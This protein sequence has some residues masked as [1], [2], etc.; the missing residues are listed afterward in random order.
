MFLG[1]DTGGTFTDFV[2]FHEGIL[3]FH[4][5]LSTP[6]DPSRAIL[7][8]IH[9]MGLQPE[10][11]HIVHGSTV[12]TNAILERKGARTLFVTNRG[13]EDLLTIGRQQRRELYRLDAPAPECW[14]QRGDCLG[15]GGRVV[16]DGS[17]SLPDHEDFIHI[18]QQAANYDAVAVCTLFSFLRPEQELALGDALN[19]HE[20]VTLSHQLLA[21]AREYERASTT[22]LNAYVGPLVQR[23]L[24]RL[25][26]ELAPRH[27]FVMH[28]AGG[29]MSVNEA[30]NQAARMVLSG[31]AGG[32]VA[33][34]RV[35]KEL[36]LSRLLT[37]DMGGTSTDVALF[38]GELRQTTEGSIAGMPVALPMLDIHTIGAGGGS[39]AW[40]DTAGLLQVGPSSAGADP[41]PVCYGR[42]ASVPTV[43]DANLFLGRIPPDARLAGTLA[44]DV[45]S[46]RRIISTMARDFALD[47]EA[48]ANGIVQVA[49]EHMAGALR[50]VSVEHGHDARQFALFCFGGAGGLHACSLAEK[51]EIPRVIVP[52]ANGAFSALGM[53]TGRRQSDLS[54]TCHLPLDALNS[55]GELESTFAE[56][57]QQ[58][59]ARM[60]GLKLHFA[61][62]LDLRYHGQGFHITLPL[63]ADAAAMKSAF[64]H[65]HEQAYGHCLDLP[66]EIITARLTAFADTEVITLPDLA[67]GE[68]EAPKACGSS[69]M[70]G[71]GEVPHFRRGNLRPGHRLS[72]PA[73]LLEETS[74]VWLPLGWELQVSTTGH[75]LLERRA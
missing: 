16:A 60:P 5:Q 72:G 18:K 40:R 9:D 19:D 69:Q 51:M 28:S 55:G 3:R 14:V 1:I 37:F 62:H 50:Q 25:G 27:L 75:L 39:L 26:Q 74:T 8:G 36:A 59:H 33:A 47:A 6:D 54:R 35:G 57:K 4:K 52:V 71:S 65:A 24:R 64:L 43:T 21:E 23:Y 29:V 15:I 63:E 10:S 11:L 12:A 7:A 34:H 13:L 70:V 68:N 20:F 2:L 48:L 66:V 44:L 31:P 56:L 17:Y 42:G 30:G 46:C 32:L 41:G 67:P 53:L 38:D 58:A 61:P 73:L 49:E 22:F 45:D